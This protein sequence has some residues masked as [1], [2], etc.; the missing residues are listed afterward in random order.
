MHCGEVSNP[1]EVFDMLMFKAERIGHGICIH[2]NYGG[3]ESTWNL[4]CNYQIPVGK[5]FITKKIF[6][7]A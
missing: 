5:L 4:I 2:P 7:I 6:Y 3:N 1:E